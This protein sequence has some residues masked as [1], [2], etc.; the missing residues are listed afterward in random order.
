M[1]D[2]DLESCEEVKRWFKGAGYDS[3]PEAERRQL[4]SELGAF[5]RFADMTPR[6]LIDSCLRTTKEGHTAIS[7]KGRRAMQQSIDA[8][9]A[10]RGLAGHQSIAAGN[11]I[12]S[13][14]VHNGVFIQGRA[15][16]H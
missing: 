10:E 5:C 2:V 16:I 3:A 15:A 12:R 8:F 9:V 4:I 6:Q 11:R 1:S 13:F 14:L 7:T